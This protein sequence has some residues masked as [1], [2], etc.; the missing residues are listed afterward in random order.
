VRG[1]EPPHRG[2]L[3][4]VGLDSPPAA[5]FGRFDFSGAD[6]PGDFRDRDTTAGGKLT[7]A[8]GLILLGHRMRPFI[9]DLIR[10]ASRIGSVQ[11]SWG[12]SKNVPIAQ[13]FLEQH[14]CAHLFSEYFYHVIVKSLL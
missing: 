5:L 4:L 14:L 3:Q 2:E 13:R 7:G 12:L 1:C 8:Q 10:S 6:Q 11:P 9:K